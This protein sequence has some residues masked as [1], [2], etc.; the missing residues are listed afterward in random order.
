MK[1][2]VALT[3][4]EL[5]NYAQLQR[6]QMDSKTRDVETHKNEVKQQ[7]TQKLNELETYSNERKRT[8][9]TILEELIIIKVIDKIIIKI[10]SG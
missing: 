5:A 3:Q 4:Q 8:L 9:D 7:M 6:Q 1:Q 2:T 10:K